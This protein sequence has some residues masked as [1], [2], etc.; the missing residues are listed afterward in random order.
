MWIAQQ[1]RHLIEHDHEADPGLEACQHRRGNEVGDESQAQEA[2]QQ[3]HRADQCGQRGRRRDQLRRV[4][5]RHDQSELRGGQDCQRCSGAD[6]QHA[7][8][9]EQR[10]DE[11]RDEGGVKTDRDRQSGDGRIGHG[12]GQDDRGGRETGNHVEAKCGGAGRA[13]RRGHRRLIHAVCS[14]LLR[15]F[16]G[17]Q[18]PQRVAGT[19]LIVVPLRRPAIRRCMCVVLHADGVGARIANETGDVGLKDSNLSESQ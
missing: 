5:I 19:S 4:A 12:L 13:C 9:A 16:D 2:R 14:R 6:A 15:E 17:S 11:H 7:R 18:V 10:V 1:F 8:S 3:Q